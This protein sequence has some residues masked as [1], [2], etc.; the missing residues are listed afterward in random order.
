[1]TSYIICL[2]F[3]AAARNTLCILTYF[4]IAAV[5]CLFP[6]RAG[7]IA[8]DASPDGLVVAFL[9]IGRAGIV[10]VCGAF[11]CIT[12]ALTL[13]RLSPLGAFVD[14][15][16]ELAA[17]LCTSGGADFAYFIACNA[18]IGI[19]AFVCAVIFDGANFCT[20]VIWIADG[21]GVCIGILYRAT[22]VD[23]GCIDGSGVVVT[24][25]REGTA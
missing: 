13:C 9:F 21:V 22:F 4:C 5:L 18:G 14:A 11:A 15:L 3:V 7:V 19:A 10:A 17:A 24:P 8:H 16:A 23:I 12:V 20:L 2:T 25:H 6:M 1:M